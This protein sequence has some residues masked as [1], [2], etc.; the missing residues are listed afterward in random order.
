MA[1]GNKVG[2]LYRC[3]EVIFDMDVEMLTGLVPPDLPVLDCNRPPDTCLDLATLQTGI[4]MELVG[5]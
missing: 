1:T 2:D 4:V 3:I 5:I